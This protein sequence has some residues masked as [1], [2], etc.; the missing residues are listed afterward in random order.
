MV[1]GTSDHA[2]GKKWAELGN[3]QK[4]KQGFG[5]GLDVG[6]R[7]ASR[8]VSGLCLGTSELVVEPLSDL[9][10]WQERNV[11]GRKDDAFSLGQVSLDIIRC[12]PGGHVPRA[13][14]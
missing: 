14:G 12:C 9:G 11:F 4:R 2:D 1:A 5:D 8:V 3:T 10:A 7:E 13:V 6:T